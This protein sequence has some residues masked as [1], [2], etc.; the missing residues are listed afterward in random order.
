MGVLESKIAASQE[1][2]SRYKREMEQASEENK[3]LNTKLATLGRI[4]SEKDTIIE[5]QT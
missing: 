1:E 2:M 5:S 3:W 4:G